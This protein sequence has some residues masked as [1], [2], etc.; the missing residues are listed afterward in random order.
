MIDKI[1]NLCFRTEKMRIYTLCYFV[2]IK[3]HAKIPD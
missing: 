1:T 3:D 2:T